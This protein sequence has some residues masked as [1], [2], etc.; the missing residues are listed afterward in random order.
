MAE[1]L[2]GLDIVE[3]KTTKQNNNKPKL[4]AAWDA[5]PSC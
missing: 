5:F 3:G 1:H 2:S 4:E